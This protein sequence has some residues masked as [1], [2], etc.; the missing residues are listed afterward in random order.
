MFEIFC[1]FFFCCSGLNM[2][3]IVSSLTSN[4]CII[5]VPFGTSKKRRFAFVIFEFLCTTP[6]NTVALQQAVGRLLLNRRVPRNCNSCSRARCMTSQQDA[7][8]KRVPPP[9]CCR[10]G[11][12]CFFVLDLLKPISRLWRIP[13]LAFARD[14]SQLAAGK[15]NISKKTLLPGHEVVGYRW[16]LVIVVTFPLSIFAKKF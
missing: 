5:H 1:S 10:R 14:Q 12:T 7:C 15:F 2:F 13:T 8:L 11:W 6:E 4:I 9:V 3:A 16:F